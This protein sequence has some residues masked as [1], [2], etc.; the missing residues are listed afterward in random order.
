MERVMKTKEEKG[1]I[2]NLIGQKFG[3]LTVIGKDPQRTNN[4]SVK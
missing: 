4:G 1:L 2:D 3:F